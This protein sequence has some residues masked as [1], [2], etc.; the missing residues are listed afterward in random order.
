MPEAFCEMHPEDA[1]AMGLKQ[2]Q[3]VKIQSRRGELSL[4]LDL[5]GRGK[6]ARGSVFVQF[7]DEARAVNLLTLDHYCPIS[8][9]PDYKKCA[10]RVEPA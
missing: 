4:K 5:R 9:E 2:G 3:M 6:P 1:Q 8:K 7:F 10:V